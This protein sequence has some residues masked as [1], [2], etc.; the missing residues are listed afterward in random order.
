MKETCRQKT[1]NEDSKNGF[2][3]MRAIYGPKSKV[4]K[5]V[6]DDSIVDETIPVHYLVSNGQLHISG[7]PSKT[8]LT[9]VI[10]DLCSS[11]IRALVKRRR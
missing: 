6:E 9:G 8:N 5:D 3:V 7:G 10:Q 11:M 2:V 4:V 1:E